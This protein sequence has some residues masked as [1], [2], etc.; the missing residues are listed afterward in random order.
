LDFYSPISFY[1]FR[2]AGI[3]V[4]TF[5][6]FRPK[7]KNSTQLKTYKTIFLIGALWVLYR[8]SVYYGF[9][10]LGVIFTTLII[11]LGPVF[12]YLFAKIFL[13]EKLSWRNIL[14][15]I[16]IVICVLYVT[17]F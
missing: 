15:A 10:Q 14:A 1:F 8:V 3:L 17:L 12:V 13:H 7:I 9:L 5:L 2:S 11:M 6:I 16:I 4:L